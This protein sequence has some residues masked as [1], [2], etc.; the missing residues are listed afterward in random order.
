MTFSTENKSS[1]SQIPVLFL[2][3][4][5]VILSGTGSTIKSSDVGFMLGNAQCLLWAI[6]IKGHFLL[7]GQ[8]SWRKQL[9][10]YHTARWEGE[11]S[12]QEKVAEG[13]I[14]KRIMEK[15]KKEESEPGWKMENW[16]VG[17]GHNISVRQERLSDKTAHIEAVKR[18]KSRVAAN[19][20]VAPRLSHNPVIHSNLYDDDAELHR[21]RQNYEY[22]SGES[23]LTAESFLLTS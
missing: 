16:N 4:I 18:N 9:L 15:K 12:K 22:S 1:S 23:E 21:W 10:Q 3:H 14:A 5:E 7:L 13:E 11:V 2:E 8:W 19:P 20:T 17:D 6:S